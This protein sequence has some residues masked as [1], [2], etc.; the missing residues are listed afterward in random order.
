MKDRSFLDLAQRTDRNSVKNCGAVGATVAR[1]VAMIETVEEQVLNL[2]AEIPGK[3]RILVPPVAMLIVAGCCLRWL[4]ALDPAWSKMLLM[5]PYMGA[6]IGMMLAV[7]FHRGRHLFLLLNL[8]IY[9]W[10]YRTFL[11][12]GSA[13]VGQE[14][15]LHALTTLLPLNAFAFTVQKE[16]GAVTEAAK[17]RLLALGGEGLIAYILF[18]YNFTQLAPLY[19]ARLRPLAAF[20]VLAISDFASTLFLLA[21]GGIATLAI[22][23]KNS[24]ETWTLGYLVA[25]FVACNGSPAS[26]A[27]SIF[28]FAATL[29][30]IAALLQESYNLAFRDDLTGIPSR[31]ALNEAMYGLGGDYAIAMVD[32]D[33]FKKFNDTYGHSVGDQ[34]LKLVAKKLSGVGGNG[35]AY[36]YGGEE[37][38]IIFTGRTLAEVAPHLEAL[39][40]E[41]AGYAMI[42]RSKDRPEDDRKGR[43]QITGTRTGPSTSVTVSIGVAEHGPGLPTPE[44]VIMAADKALYRAKQLG[45]NQV[46]RQ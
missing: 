44:E 38:A 16:R 19:H 6:L 9:Y 17:F 33:Y 10:C 27:T 42:L 22:R 23:R 29:M 3:W 41:I 36:R 40:Q 46:S 18:H 32:V 28:S 24:M 1:T 14:A 7:H 35:K 15:L 13:G 34:V 45:R 30:I 25:L 20:D 2:L 43:K 31:R 5:A 21:A 26:E 4:P 37:F 8:A 12:A 11:A 39:R